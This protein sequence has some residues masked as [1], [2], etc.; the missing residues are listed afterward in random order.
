MKNPAIF[1][2]PSPPPPSPANPFFCFISYPG[3]IPSFSSLTVAKQYF[4]S[5]F[6][7]FFYCPEKNKN[8][9]SLFSKME[10]RFF[11]PSS[12]ATQTRGNNSSNLTNF[13]RFYFFLP[14]SAAKKRERR[15]KKSPITER[16]KKEE[17]K[18][19]NTKS[20]DGKLHAVSAS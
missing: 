16:E 9:F 5:S 18:C 17:L 12:F 6:R 19:E 3:K 15:K 2:W 8:A 11:S 7:T 14:F 20:R 10:P 4:F 1:D 13:Q